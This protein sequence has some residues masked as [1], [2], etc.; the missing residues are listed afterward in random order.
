MSLTAQSYAALPA[1]WDH[2]HMGNNVFTDCVWSVGCWNILRCCWT[3]YR[4]YEGR[5]L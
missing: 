1:I 5:S 3:W 4:L 2:T